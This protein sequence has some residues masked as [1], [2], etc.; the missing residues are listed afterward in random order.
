MNSDIADLTKQK[1]SASADD[2]LDYTLQIQN[3]QMSVRQNEYSKQS[4]QTDITK[5][6]HEN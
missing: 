4:K 6:Q 1:V 2:Q 5:Y 3:K